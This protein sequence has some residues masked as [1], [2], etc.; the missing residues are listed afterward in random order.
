MLNVAILT[1]NTGPGATV[2]ALNLSNVSS[3]DFDFRGSMIRVVHGTPDKVFD[4]AWTD[5]TGVVFSIV[6]GVATVTIT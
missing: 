5:V 4:L 3:I 2:T 1:G 6:S